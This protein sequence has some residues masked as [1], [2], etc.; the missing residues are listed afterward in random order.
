MTY[1]DQSSSLPTFKDL[2]KF[3]DELER[4]EK[5]VLNIVDKN[6]GLTK[7]DVVNALDGR[8]S[9]V[10]VFDVIKNLSDIGIIKIE[11]EKPNSQIHR[12]YFNKDNP[13]IV[14]RNQIDRFEEYYM[15]ARKKIHTVFKKK[16]TQLTKEEKLEIDVLI[17][18][19]FLFY[20]HYVRHFTILAWAGSSKA[21]SQDTS[22]AMSDRLRRMT[23]T[24]IM[25]TMLLLPNPYQWPMTSILE[26]YGVNT[27]VSLLELMKMCS[28]KYGINKELNAM[29][30]LINWTY[31]PDK[32][33]Y[34]NNKDIEESISKKNIKT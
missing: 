28:E 30:E 13:L 21:Q 15:V 29:I 3:H 11:K 20:V 25:D 1:V 5:L 27:N 14:A 34:G 24:R 22:Q 26:I 2:D 12:L 31:I 19:L 6:P 18:F 10:T 16:H 32:E 17:D 8:L 4:K 33:S 9:R 7:Q 23:F